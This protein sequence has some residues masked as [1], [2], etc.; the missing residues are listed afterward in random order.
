MALYRAFFG[1]TESVKGLKEAV[2]HLLPG[3][4]FPVAISGQAL[5][6]WDID[7]ILD[8]FREALDYLVKENGFFPSIALASVLAHSPQDASRMA[9]KLHAIREFRDGYVP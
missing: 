1:L 7:R 4:P 3:L 8:F 9:D 5:D 6:A 2:R